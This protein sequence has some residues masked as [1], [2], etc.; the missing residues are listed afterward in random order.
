MGKITFNRINVKGAQKTLPSNRPSDSVSYQAI[1][2][3]SATFKRHD[4]GI[5]ERCSDSISSS[6]NEKENNGSKIRG[7]QVKDDSLTTNFHD[8]HN[9]SIGSKSEL[10]TSDPALDYKFY[11]DENAYTADWDLS[12]DIDDPQMA[13]LSQYNSNGLRL[14]DQFYAE[15]QRDYYMNLLEKERSHAPNPRYISFQMNRALEQSVINRKYDQCNSNTNNQSRN[16]WTE[17]RTKVVDWLFEFQDHFN[18]N[19]AMVSAETI[20]L[21]ITYIDR[22]L[23]VRVADFGVWQE[24]AVTA[25]FIAS[26][27]VDYQSPSLK[28]L[29]EVTAESV[30]KQQIL[31]REKCLLKIFTCTLCSPTTYHFL[32]ELISSRDL[33]SPE[34]R[35]V[36]RIALHFCDL[37]RLDFDLLVHSNRVMSIACLFLGFTLAGLTFR[38]NSRTTPIKYMNIELDELVQ[39]IN[40]LVSFYNKPC[41]LVTMPKYHVKQRWNITCSTF[42][43]DICPQ[44]VEK[45]LA[46]LCTNW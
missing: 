21:A 15:Y 6:Y 13:N 16:R 19:Q 45:K 35:Q 34:Y 41:S 43:N 1:P 24:I 33:A 37:S 10:E 14:Y 5:Y 30:S 46:L 26:K 29:S 22:Y 36:R 38:L 3:Y 4:S 9:L 7:V 31:A 42:R 27:F 25:A 18:L 28:Q 44:L 12:N 11:K 39:C 23:S 8:L 2:Q 40:K 32:I 17:M 20:H